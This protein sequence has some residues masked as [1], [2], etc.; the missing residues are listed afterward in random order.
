MFERG[1]SY[2]YA[3]PDGHFLIVLVAIVLVAI[4]VT[5]LGIYAI[6]TYGTGKTQEQRID[7]L[8]NAAIGEVT[9][10]GLGVAGQQA[11]GAQKVVLDAASDANDLGDAVRPLL[12]EE[13]EKEE[14]KKAPKLKLV[15][16]VGQNG[17]EIPMLVPEG[18]TRL[19]RS[20]SGGGRRSNVEVVY[21]K[22]DG[23]E[24]YGLTGTEV[25]EGASPPPPK[26]DKK[27]SKKDK[28]A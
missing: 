23:T 2:K 8:E 9:G 16:Y 27:P 11:T 14:E 7:Y 3:D 17:K 20:G 26:E 19:T 10:L 21:I 22:D 24:V 25:P 13:E 5:K 6:D 4:A 1:N 12:R 28:K 15:Y 18:T